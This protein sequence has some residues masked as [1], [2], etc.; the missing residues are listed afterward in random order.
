MSEFLVLGGN[1]FIGSH[2]LDELLAGGAKPRVFDRHPEAFREPLP[3]VDYAF[4]SFD[5][6]QDLIPALRGA[7]VVFHL[8]ST[9]YPGS[10]ALDPAFD[11]TSNLLPT[12]TLMEEAAKAGVKRVV[13]LSSGGAIYG[14]PAQLPVSEDSLKNP[15][16]PYGITKLAI[17]KYLNYYWHQ[18]GIEC[19]MARPSNAYGPRQNPQNAQGLIPVLL[20]RL[21]DRQPIEIWGDGSVTR[22]Y[23]YVQD[24]ARGVAALAK[25]GTPGKA[26]NFGSGQGH[27]VSEI[28]ARIEAVTGLKAE[29][30]RAPARGI[31]VPKVWLDIKRAKDELG[32]APQ[33]ALEEG[34]SLTWD[35]VRKET[36]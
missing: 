3:G 23:I 7:R 16:S 32:W 14:E 35:A 27:S 36:H 4:G 22:D 6:R 19:L 24:L 29:T 20:R 21:R 31:D 15:S 26:Y 11:V 5:H 17:E 13:F 9:T 8:V 30:R 34:I 10:S 18:K 12:L 1:G 2:L 33:V 28:L 25:G